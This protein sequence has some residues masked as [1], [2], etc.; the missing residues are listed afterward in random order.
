MKRRLIAVLLI[1]CCFAMGA[2]PAS[3]EES[4]SY[5]HNGREYFFSDPYVE[6]GT[7]FLSAFPQDLECKLLMVPTNTVIQGSVS[8]RGYHLDDTY[9]YDKH[10]WVN[11]FSEYRS[12][13]ASHFFLLKDDDVY[14]FDGFCVFTEGNLDVLNASEDLVIPGKFPEELALVAPYDPTTAPPVET[15]YNDVSND[16]FYAAGIVYVTEHGLMNG[17]GNSTFSPNEK[18]NRAQVATLLY[19]MEGS[20]D[21]AQTNIFGDVPEDEWY[22]DAVSWAASEGIVNGTGDGYFSPMLEI[23]REQLAAMIERYTEAKEI[24]LP[25]AQKYVSGFKDTWYVSPYAE[26][27]VRLVWR[28]GIMNGD[29]QYNFGPK[30]I[31]DRAEAADILMRLDRAIGGEHLTVSIPDTTPDQSL[32]SKQEKNEMALE[33][34]KQIASVVPTDCS[35]LERVSIAAQIVS[36]YCSFC[37]YTMGGTDYRTP[38]GVFIKGEYSCAGSTRALGMVL[39]CMGYSWTHANENQYSHQWCELVMDGQQGFADGQVGIAGYGPCW[40]A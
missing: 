26:D 18:L 30:T 24:E 7:I 20:P 25:T 19:R 8:Y 12:G 40:T 28:V 27:G 10:E 35:D 2:I 37:W 11:I 17:T 6:Y 9:D 23:T 13:S 36:Y 14:Y 38:Y 1:A 15:F 3:A 29:S 32:L 5:L 39:E 16:D 31:V 33:V 21:Q 4:Y 22:T 34:A